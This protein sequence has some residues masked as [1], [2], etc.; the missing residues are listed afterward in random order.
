MNYIIELI[1]DYNIFRTLQY[2]KC[3]DEYSRYFEMSEFYLAS[4]KLEACLFFKPTLKYTFVICPG[5]RRAISK[6]CRH[7]INDFVYPKYFKYVNLPDRYFYTN[8]KAT[9]R[10]QFL[11]D[12]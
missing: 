10:Q 3:L 4:N 5:Y 1:L 12:L 8:S 2:K 11:T 7:N 6:I 9:L